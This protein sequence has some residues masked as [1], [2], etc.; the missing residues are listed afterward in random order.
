[1]SHEQQAVV[2]ALSRCSVVVQAVPGAG[3][4]TTA[5]SV[6]MSYPSEQV[7]LVTYSSTLKS[8][9]RDKVASGNITNMRVH[10]FHSLANEV[11]G[12]TGYTN[13]VIK[14]AVEATSFSKP[15]VVDVL[16]VDEAQDMTQLLFALVCQTCRFLRPRCMLV[17]GDERQAIYKYKNAESAYLTA[18]PERLAT[19]LGSAPSFEYLSMTTSFRLTKHMAEFANQVLL[20]VDC[21][22]AVKDGPPVTLCQVPSVIDINNFKPHHRAIASTNFNNFMKFAIGL[23]REHGV[24]NTFLLFPSTKMKS[25]LGNPT[26]AYCVQM[27]LIDACMPVYISNEFGSAGDDVLAGKVV[28]STFHA[29]K[30]RERKLVFVFNFGEDYYKFYNPDV[31]AE[32]R[33]SNP[34]FV[35]MT[36]ASEKLVAVNCNTPLPNFCSTDV[37]DDLTSRGVCDTVSFVDKMKVT[38]LTFKQKPGC[39]AVTEFVARLDDDATMDIIDN[40]NALFTTIQDKHMNLQIPTTVEMKTGLIEDV[41]LITSYV[42]NDK[43]NHL[44]EGRSFIDD[45]IDDFIE[46]GFTHAM[47]SETQCTCVSNVLDVEADQ[48]EARLRRAIAFSAIADDHWFRTTQTDTF[49]WLTQQQLDSAI[50]AQQRLLADKTTECEWDFVQGSLSP[51]EQN[52]ADNDIAEAFYA[53]IGYLKVLKGRLDI[54]TPTCVFENK[55]TTDLTFEHKLQLVVYNYMWQTRMRRLKGQ[56]RFLLYSQL[57]GELL[58]LCDKQMHTVRKIVRRIAHAKWGEP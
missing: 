13:E 46:S 40:V 51:K 33:C 1:M 30:G 19:R 4:T 21:L 7:L 54:L 10:S 49:N 39:L 5:L 55:A 36:R 43:A 31:D 29:A 3:K 11:M 50:E 15:F 52:K 42:I 44:L 58:E 18:F 14:R 48:I 2:R 57:T 37:L 28:L 9:T 45:R 41:S 22:W 8:E 16:I 20:G 34:M 6:S 35:A 53:D 25:R 56:R 38:E 47:G 23:I 24:H 17:L 27:A 32:T 12:T 26:L